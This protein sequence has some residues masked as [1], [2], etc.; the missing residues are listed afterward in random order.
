MAFCD[1]PVGIEAQ[2]IAVRF[3]PQ[4]DN[5]SWIRAL[6]YCLPILL[7]KKPLMPAIFPTYL[8]PKT[9]IQSS[10]DSVMNTILVIYLFF[11]QFCMWSRSVYASQVVP[12][13]S[14][15][16]RISSIA[17]PSINMLLWPIQVFSSYS[18]QKEEVSSVKR[19][20]HSPLFWMLYVLLFLRNQGPRLQ[21][22]LSMGS[23]GS[24][25]KLSPIELSLFVLR[26]I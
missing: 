20:V 12:H 14:S 17:H 9:S 15:L 23:R 5:N 2:D 1:C 25:E 6:I 21:G 13:V 11:P 24:P 19:V 4:W 22:S 8:T 18:L 3:R 10:F 16:Q 7:P 26:S